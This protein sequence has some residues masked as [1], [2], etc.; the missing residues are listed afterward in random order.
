MYKKGNLFVDEGYFYVE[1]V[2]ERT[3][4]EEMTLSLISFSVQVLY[5]Y[6]IRNFISLARMPGSSLKDKGGQR[7]K[8]YTLVG[9]CLW[10]H[11]YY[12]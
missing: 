9:E 3:E 10:F 1:T 12:Y 7:R 8:L 2:K 6:L 5:G 11:F 4:T